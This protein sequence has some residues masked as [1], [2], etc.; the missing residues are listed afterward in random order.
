MVPSIL[1]LVPADTRQRWKGGSGHVAR[2]AGRK[3]ALA[4]AATRVHAGDCAGP[5]PDRLPARSGPIRADPRVSESAPSVNVTV[6]S[7]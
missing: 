7:S 1:E 4:L 6:P 5:G 2:P 3:G